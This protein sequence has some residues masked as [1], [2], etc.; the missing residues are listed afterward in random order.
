MIDTGAAPSIVKLKYIHADAYLNTGD[1]LTLSGITA[2]KTRTLGSIKILLHGHSL[3]LNVVNNNFPIPQEGILGSDFLQYA[4]RIDFGQKYILWQGMQIPFTDEQS[5]IVPP[6]SEI[7]LNVKVVYPEI[8]TGYIPR[9]RACDGVYM[10]DAIVTAQKGRINLK[11]INTLEETLQLHIP[12]LELQEMEQI[13]EDTPDINE[14]IKRINAIELFFFYRSPLWIPPSPGRERGYV[15]LLLTKTLR[16]IS[17][18]VIR[19]GSGVAFHIR[20]E[21]APA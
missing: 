13:K 8:K 17:G 1:I 16:W 19:A 9:L 12:T 10:G 6:R 14:E 3:T 15:R 20:P 21:P 2:E 18:A 5:A 11:V 4:S 7:T